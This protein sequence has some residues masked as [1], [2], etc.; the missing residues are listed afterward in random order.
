MDYERTVRVPLA[1]SE[2]FAFLGDESRLMSWRD[3]LVAFKRL[4]DGAPDAASRR[5]AETLDTPL[6][7]QTMTVALHSDAVARSFRFEVLDGPVR[8]RGEMTVLADGD[9]S[10]LVYKVTHKTLLPVVTPID[11]LV[12]DALVGSVDRSLENVRRLLAP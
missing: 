9:G 3:G 11:K 12:F 7:K 4:D 10:A 8:P 6:G 2:L 1:P 5:Y